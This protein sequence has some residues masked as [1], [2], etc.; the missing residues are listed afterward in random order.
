MENT[1]DSLL[2]NCQD[3]SGNKSLKITCTYERTYI[4]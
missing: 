3:E 4:K 2:L 1:D